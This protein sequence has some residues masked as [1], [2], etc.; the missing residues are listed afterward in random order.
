[1][2][3]CHQYNDARGF[4]WQRH[5][6]AGVHVSERLAAQGFLVVEHDLFGYGARNHDAGLAYWLAHPDRSALGVM[7]SDV[8][9]IVDALYKLD[10]HVDTDRLALTGYSLGGLVAV[11]A[12]ALDKRV[13]ACV[14]VCGLG[15]LRLDAH[16]EATEGLGR[17]CLLRPTLPRLGFFLGQERRVPY[18]VHE[19]LALIAP[20]P[21]LIVVPTLDQDWVHADVRACYQAAREAY[22][23]LGAADKL[24]FCA[25]DDFGRFPPRLQ[26]TV[27]AWLAR[28]ASGNVNR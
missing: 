22:V 1:V 23:F 5:E 13:G 28:W 17:Y 8:R 11:H 9:R 26:R 3:Y 4:A 16:G 24:V 7:V 25:P 27:N 15:S 21:V 12:A 6:Q 10:L 20:R 2:V 14:S 19:L 18:D